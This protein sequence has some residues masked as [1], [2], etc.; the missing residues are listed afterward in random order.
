MVAETTHQGA[1]KVL[2]IGGGAA[3]LVTLR[4]LLDVKRTDGQPFFDV[5]LVERRDNVGGVWYWND[6][7]YNLERRLT[8]LRTQGVWPLLDDDG[9]AHWPSPAYLNLR[10][11]VLPE[12]LQF[13]G[14]PF[15]PPAHGETFPTLKETHDYLCSFAEPL[16]HH[17]KCGIEVVRAEELIDGGWEVEWKDWNTAAHGSIAT[18]ANGSA[19]AAS[20]AQSN[21]PHPKT[22]VHHFDRVVIACGWY[23]TPLYPRAE[24]IDEA[25][26]AGFVHHAKHYR[27]SETYRGKK[28]VVV[29]NNNSSNEAAMHLAVHRTA[30]NP[31]Y[32]SAKRPPIVKCP[33]LPDE[34][35]RDIGVIQRYQVTETGDGTKRLDLHIADGT[36]VENVDYVLLG[37]GYGLC[38]PFVRVLTDGARKEGKQETQKLTP[39]E[40]HGVRVPNL[41]RHVLYAKSPELSLAF[42][43]LVVSFFPFN[44]ADLTSRW[45]SYL[46]TGPLRSIVPDDVETRLE[47]ER[48]RL[49]YLVA[50]KRRLLAATI[51]S[52]TTVNGS[53]GA[54]DV[55]V[56]ETDPYTYFGFHTIAGSLHAPGP[57]EIE[58]GAQLR[59]ELVEAVPSMAQLYDEWGEERERKQYQMYDTK[60]VWLEKNEQRIRR[61]PF[62]LLGRNERYRHLVPGMVEEGALK[63]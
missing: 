43:G 59:R 30:A 34:R 63:S 48:E 4:N 52:T 49:A 50:E 14:H 24:G 16:R 53:A 28:V 32:K 37:T 55:G 31:V 61:D 35:I 21:G 26:R 3:G 58:Y 33:C 23:D 47:D 46:W 27:D 18:E 7:T 40:L 62:D 60:R 36:V 13:T 6:A 1:E 11:N 17:I 5:A 45:L 15:P 19:A 9:R 2:V 39:P 44:L 51:T 12:Y 22:S 57:S 38:F 42:V 10:G 20:S 54:G 25:R 56:D 8:P 29:G 41:H